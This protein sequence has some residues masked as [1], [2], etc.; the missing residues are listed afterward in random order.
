MSKDAWKKSVR[1]NPKIEKHVEGKKIPDITL[2]DFI[3]ENVSLDKG[4]RIVKVDQKNVFYDKYRVT[5]W[6]ERPNT[7]SCVPIYGIK[8]SFLLNYEDEVLEDHTIRGDGKC[9]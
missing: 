5:V 9:L 1:D 4:E 2:I 8:D 3:D 7:E 6:V